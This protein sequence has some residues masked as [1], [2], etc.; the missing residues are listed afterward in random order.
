MQN[1]TLISNPLK[2]LLKKHTQKVIRIYLG[3]HQRDCITK[4]LKSLYPYMYMRFSGSE[5]DRIEIHSK[6][7]PYVDI[8]SVHLSARVLLG[9]VQEESNRG[10]ERRS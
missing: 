9:R 1:F 8:T 6:Q 2:K 3:N 5:Y 4:L 10:T 7:I